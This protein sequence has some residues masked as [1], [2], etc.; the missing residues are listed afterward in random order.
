MDSRQESCATSI[1]LPTRFVR[2]VSTASAMA[3]GGPVHPVSMLCCRQQ[4][5]FAQPKERSIMESGGVK[6]EVRQV[7]DLIASVV[8]I[9]VEN[10]K[11]FG[12]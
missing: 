6:G 10:I 3:V 12:P 1:N 9:D 2:Y 7:C 11:R 4:R 8:C 5:T